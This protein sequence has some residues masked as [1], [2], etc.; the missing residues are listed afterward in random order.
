MRLLFLFAAAAVALFVSF[1]RVVSAQAPTGTIT[2]LVLDSAS[3]KPVEFATVTL[4]S[5]TTGQPIDGTLTNG[6]GSFTFSK[7]TFGT[8]SVT[9]SYLGYAANSLSAFTLS[10]QKPE[11]T[12][13]RILLRANPTKLQ[14]ITVVGQKP[15]VE[16]KGDRLVYN[17]EQ[18]LT[19]R[20][21]T[22]S[23][24]LR[25]APSVTVDGEGNVQLRGSSNFR[26]LMDGRPSSILANNLAEALKQIPADI[27]KSIEVITSPSAKYDAE[28]TAGIINIITKKNTLE[29]LNGKL[30][31]TV[32]NRSN[33]ANGTL[34]VRKGK[35]GVN[36]QASIYESRFGRGS[37]V[38]RTGG[39]FFRQ[40]ATGKTSNHGFYGQ[41]ELTF[42][43]DTLNAFHLSGTLYRSF[44]TSRSNQRTFDRQNQFLSYLENLWNS[45]GHDLNLGYT[46]TFKPQHELSLLAQLSYNNSHDLYHNQQFTAEDAQLLDQANDNL[47]PTRE[48]TVQID[49][50]RTFA[51]ES[52]L[53]V[54]AKTILRDARSNTTY[55]YSFLAR[56]DSVVIN[57]FDYYQHVAAAYVTYAFKVRKKY[58]FH[59]GTRYERT[60]YKGLF[61]NTEWEKETK[62]SRL[63]NSFFQDLYK[64]VIPSLTVSRTLDSIHTVRASYTQRIQ[65]PQIFILNPFLQLED[66][67][68]AFRGNP[69]LDAELTHSF[70]LGYS[71]YFKTT[72]LN[73]ALYLRQTD[74]DIQ[75]V[76]R[77]EKIMIDGIERDVLLVTYD[78]VA[79]NRAVGFSLSG[80]T[81]PFP[82]W[83]ISP[84]VNVTYLVIKSDSLRNKGLQ[85]NANLNTS[86]EIGKGWSAQAYA[87]YYSGTRTLQGERGANHYSNLSVRKKIMKEK[88][89]ISFGVTNPFTKTLT[90]SSTYETPQYVQESHHFNY[91]RTVRLT[92]DWNFGKMQASQRQKKAIQND[93]AAGGGK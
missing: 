90:Y 72:S 65:R 6:K 20:G 60:A 73:A 81:K 55:N 52:K 25:K 41:T 44:Y 23:D 78:N 31:A 62:S 14:E 66:F 47:S 64:N 48:T 49:Y 53:E 4:T 18:D 3:S 12:F 38:E 24:V 21:T 93:D 68:N 5:T 45:S 2:G 71:T 34:N 80:S 70:E 75:T 57:N 88:G 61:L 36:T 37:L 87:S 92:F 89:S 56:Q 1:P 82:A 63:V 84:S 54:G 74:N 42:D 7:V 85:Y 29:G 19:N 13:V 91:N 32:G 11:V 50:N 9:V 10:P 16:D 83:T 33:T 69:T 43:P 26:V 76:A 39:D 15:L 79:K 58:N 17:A 59:L 77:P 27:I 67:N 40:E 86:Y 46:H 35:F 28:G 51:N 30:G 8:Y 22:A